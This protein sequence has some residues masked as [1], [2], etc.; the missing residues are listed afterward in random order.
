MEFHEERAVHN[1]CFSSSGDRVASCSGTYGDSKTGIWELESR[2]R[3]Y[4]ITNA[5]NFCMHYVTAQVNVS[6]INND[7]HLVIHTHFDLRVY[8]IETSEVLW[9]LSDHL[10]MSAASCVAVHPHGDGAIVGL[11]SAGGWFTSDV[12]ILDFWSGRTRRSVE[13]AVI[14]EAKLCTMCYDCSGTLLAAGYSNRTVIIFET[15]TWGR[16]ATFQCEYV[17]HRIVFQ[18][19]GVQ[20]AVCANDWE[21]S[22]GI[23]IWNL[24]TGVPAGRLPSAACCCYSQNLSILL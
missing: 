19:S 8:V 13:C 10:K 17:P 11:Q 22:M 1:V 14:N 3:I 9:R 12:V 7:S 16:T 2:S 18:G 6:F 5:F 21:L 24:E 4:N 15:A 20:L 23:F